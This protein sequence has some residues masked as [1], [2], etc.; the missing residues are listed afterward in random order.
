MASR[1]ASVFRGKSS[2][3]QYQT[4]KWRCGCIFCCSKGLFRFVRVDTFPKRLPTLHTC[5]W[6]KDVFLMGSLSASRDAGGLF[7]RNPMVVYLRMST[8]SIDVVEA[9]VTTHCQNV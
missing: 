3:R 5:S 4:R 6:L 1:S 7:N 9:F 8:A 2:K